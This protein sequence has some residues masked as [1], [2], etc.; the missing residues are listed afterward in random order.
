MSTDDFEV[1]TLLS[2]PTP[3]AQSPSHHHASTHPPTHPQDLPLPLLFRRAEAAFQ[4]LTTTPGEDEAQH[5]QQRIQRITSAIASLERAASL[6]DSLGI[7][8]P[9]EDKDD[10]A[11]TDVKLLLIPHYHAELLASLHEHHPNS[12]Q[13]STL[14][15]KRLKT[16][17]AS[18]NLHQAFLQRVVQYGAVSSDE[19]RRLVALVLDLV[20]SNERMDAATLRQLKIDKFKL[21]KKAAVQLERLSSLQRHNNDNDDDD[22]NNT[23]GDED[24][25]REAA[26]LRIEAVALKSIDSL[27]SL[28]QEVVVL[29]HASNLSLEERQQVRDR[30]KTPQ[31]D[32]LSELR[33]AADNLCIGTSGSGSGSGG[34][35]M[36]QREELRQAVFRPSHVLPSM[37]VEEWGDIEVAQAM[38]RQRKEKEEAER[39]K[40]KEGDNNDADDDVYR[41]RAMDDWKDDNPRGWGNSK[42]RPS[43]G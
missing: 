21:E 15:K 32:L 4:N 19:S 42:L 20:D 24:L 7:F 29:R 8:S 13:D 39:R 28:Q 12:S 6:V 2:R 37:T 11:T 5:Q 23:N 22:S 33:T 27:H 41:Q 17:L 38:E 40:K 18:R 35:A 26:F 10:L 14:I 30:T 34:T 16:L 3:H 43:G 9:N 1:T 25:E 36:S 31:Q